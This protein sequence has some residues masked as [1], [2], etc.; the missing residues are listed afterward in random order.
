MY[1]YK[2]SQKNSQKVFFLNYLGL[3]HLFRN[4]NVSKFCSQNQN[5]NSLFLC[6]K[7]TYSFLGCIVFVMFQTPPD[8]LQ[9]P[10]DILQTLPDIFQTPP[11]RY[12][13]TCII[14]WDQCLKFTC[15]I[16]YA[17]WYMIH[18]AWLWWL[19]LLWWLRSLGSHEM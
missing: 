5:L 15:Y 4:K 7:T 17:I 2:S 16:L 8:M 6:S 1:K 19:W 10:T 14:Y 9:T 13:Q 18:D 12:H 3:T 11:D